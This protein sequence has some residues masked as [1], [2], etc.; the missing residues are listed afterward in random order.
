MSQEQT[1]KT[2]KI[3]TTALFVAT[4]LTA[5]VL[6][7]FFPPMK[8]IGYQTFLGTLKATWLS[9]HKWLGIAFALVAITSFAISKQ[10]KNEQ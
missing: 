7:I 1:K 8:G 10:K 6:I 5:L 2:L 9:I 4:L 3:I